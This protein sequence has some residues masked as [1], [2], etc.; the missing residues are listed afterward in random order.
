MLTPLERAR[1]VVA[2]M[3]AGRHWNEV[4]RVLP[5]DDAA[6]AAL[7]LKA[8]RALADPGTVA[9]LADAMLADTSFDT[10]EEAEGYALDALNHILEIAGREGT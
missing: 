8:L 10:L 5:P 4:A 1:A 2:G 7:G 9:K 3:T 6:G